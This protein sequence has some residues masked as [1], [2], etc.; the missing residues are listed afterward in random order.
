MDTQ[1]S[2]IKVF[3]SYSHKDE[4]I[5]ELFE[6]HMSGLKRSGL[7]DEWYDRMILPGQFGDHEIITKLKKADIVLFLVSA[8]FIDSKYCNDI[9]VVTAMERHNQGKCIV[10]PILIR[11]CDWEGTPFE[12]IQ[13]LPKDMKP[14]VSRYW[15]DRDEALISVVIELKK[16]IKDKY[17]KK[18]KVIQDKIKKLNSSNKENDNIDITI[19][20]LIDGQ[21]TVMYALSTTTTI[22]KIL[23]E[24]FEKEIL[25]RGNKY[26]IVNSENGII[27]NVNKTIKEN[28][29][30]AGD[31]LLV[32]LIIKIKN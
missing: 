20:N 16:I 23:N 9:E 5:R 24:L 2:K 31:T 18:N 7:I 17:N 25:I 26:S 21:E 6:A 28:H 14:V 22:R 29:I 19:R 10:I 3:Y 13:G 11:E 32:S 1:E 8:W 27:L 4:E 30:K 15:F 12:H